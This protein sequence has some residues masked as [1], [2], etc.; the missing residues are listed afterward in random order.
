MIKFRRLTWAGHE[1][2]M[3]L[4]AFK[5]L[6]GKPIGNSLLGRPTHRWEANIGTNLKYIGVDTRNLIDSAQGSTEPAGS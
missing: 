4:S 3:E 2:R 5:I 6:T 1:A